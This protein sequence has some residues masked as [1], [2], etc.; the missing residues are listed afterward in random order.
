M[1]FGQ[2]GSGN[3][4]DVIQVSRGIEQDPE[5]HRC[6]PLL[7]AWTAIACRSSNQGDGG[8]RTPRRRIAENMFCDVLLIPVPTSTTVS[9]VS[10]G[11]ESITS[12]TSE[13]NDV[14]A[15]F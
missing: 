14:Y 9:H 1:V 15:S 8:W 3:S 11:S 5:L 4:D 7:R 10:Y 12:M 6:L 13:E 2:G